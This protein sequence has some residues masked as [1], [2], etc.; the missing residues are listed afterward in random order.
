[1]EHMNEQLLYKTYY[2]Q[3]NQIWSRRA[4]SEPATIRSAQFECM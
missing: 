2:P 3:N 4:S 1:M